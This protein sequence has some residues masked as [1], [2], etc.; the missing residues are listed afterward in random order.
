[1]GYRTVR[2]TAKRGM[3]VALALL[4]L[5]V[6][7]T[8]AGCLRSEKV[9][10]VRAD[11][12]GYVEE[13]FLMRSEFVQMI[14]GMSQ[15]GEEFDLV[16]RE[17]LEAQ[18]ADMG[19]GVSLESVEPLNNDWGEGYVARYRFASIKNVRVNQNPGEN[20]PSQGPSAGPETDTTEYIRFDF[21]EG[22]PSTLT[23]ALP[24]KT[25][26]TDSGESGSAQ[27]GSSSSGQ[28]NAEQ[29]QQ[30][31]SFYEDMRIHMAV[32]VDGTIVNT[33]ATHRDGQ[34]ITLMDLNFNEILEDEELTKQLLSD[35]ADSL[36]DLQDR[37][38]EYP[39]VKVEF[40]EQV[41]VDMR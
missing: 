21:T 3:K 24:E 14:A 41:N 38:K 18:A 23:I 12:S 29:M 7:L 4:L 6:I 33:N 25:T 36:T 13:T 32:K 9:V 27:S 37:L 17:K 35:E 15:Q 30:V 34:T 16:D 2:R 10:T 40:Q 19:D 20:V 1:M 11:G 26:S 31:M 8:T 28:P 39:G 5:G 22:N